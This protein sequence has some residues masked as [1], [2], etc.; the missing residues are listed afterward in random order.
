[1]SIEE[2]TSIEEE[3]TK[4]LQ[5]IRDHSRAL[6]KSLTL[7][8]QAWLKKLCSVVDNYFW[9]KNRNLYAEVLSLMLQD[10]NM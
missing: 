10:E 3:F 5:T 7:R 1:M 2:L 6:S 4:H 8:V 9:R